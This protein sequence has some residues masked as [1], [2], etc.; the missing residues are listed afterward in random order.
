MRPVFVWLHRYVGLA[1]AAFLFIEGVTGAI[2]A[3]RAELT[4]VLD[5]RFVAAAHPPGAQRLSLAA[6]ARRAEALEPTEQVA[7]FSENTDDRVTLRM[8]GRRNPETGGRFPDEPFHVMLDPFTGERLAGA[9]PT[10]AS[11]R[12]FAQVMPFVIRLHLH[13]TFGEPGVWALWIV[14]L[15]WTIDC[16]VGFY[17]TLPITFEKFWRRWKPAWLVK[18]RGGF[19][20]INFDLHRASGLWLWL[21]LFVFAWSSVE[22][23]DRLGLFDWVMGQVT[24][25][26][27]AAPDDVEQFPARESV[28]PFKL[29]W[30]AAEAEGGRLMAEE[31]ARQGFKILRPFSLNRFEESRLYNYTVLTDRSFP[32]DQE[33]TVFFDADTGAFHARMHANQGPADDLLS[34]WLRGLHMI[35]DPVDYF[36]YRVF[37]V[38]VGLAVAG[39]S[40]TGVY[41]WWKKRKARVLRRSRRS[42]VA[43]RDAA[44]ER[45]SAAG[46]PNM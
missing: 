14:A 33:W 8:R 27:A 3:F 34:N 42:E 36:A 11:A 16:F 30:E 37:V 1:L 25:F 10:S 31:S 19:Y 5:P 12:F 4:G 32:Q 39:L 7:Y 23:T 43:S 22:L 38:V 17:L 29:D 26:S 6:L 40:V 2:L 18:W 45:A 44:C 15:C 41:I 9:E 13:L 20:R 46:N 28:A 21:L 35:R 24:A